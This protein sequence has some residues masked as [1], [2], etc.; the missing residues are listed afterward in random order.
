MQRE[1]MVILGSFGLE[2]SSMLSG[3]TGMNEKTLEAVK[4]VVAVTAIAV[5]AVKA[6]EVLLGIL[7]FVTVVVGV[8]LY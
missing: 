8:I 2:S 7:I 5:V 3:R 4:F 1:G 6:P